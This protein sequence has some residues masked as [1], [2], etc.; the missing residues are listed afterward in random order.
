MMNVGLYDRRVHAKFLA[1]FQT[2]IHCRLHDQLIDGLQRLRSQSVKGTVES[3]VLRHWLAVEF[4][5]LTQRVAVSDPF[6]QLAKIPILDPLEDQGAQHLLWGQSIATGPEIFQAALQITS[7]CLDHLFVVVKKI[8]DALQWLQQNALLQ[9]LPI[10]ETDLRLRSSRHASVLRFFRSL[11]P[12]PFQRL[13][14]ARCGLVE[15]FLQST[16]VV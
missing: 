2:Q 7:Y 8:T 14:I 10:G 4:R 13:D 9:Q 5:K 12:L 16:P 6:A 3:T 1:I 11:I 15:Q